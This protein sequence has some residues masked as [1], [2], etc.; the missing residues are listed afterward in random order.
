MSTKGKRDF[1]P[2]LHFS[3]KT[4]W[5]NDPNGMV[6]ADGV[7][8]LFAQHYPDDT[9]WGPMHWYHVTS[10]DLIHWEHHPIALYPDELGW[11]FSG[12]AVLDK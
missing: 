9:H 7:Y 11:I 2:Q 5:V 4:G 10:T 6:Y 1:R 8:H 12:S 3:P